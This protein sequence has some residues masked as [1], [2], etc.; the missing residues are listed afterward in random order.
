[1]SF[2]FGVLFGVQC[3]SICLIPVEIFGK[4][5]LTVVLGQNFFWGGIGALFGAPIAGD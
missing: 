5:N 3:V 1:L 2:I 4:E